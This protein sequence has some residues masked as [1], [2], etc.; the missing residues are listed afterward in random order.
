M[1]V[2]AAN[3]HIQE[4]LPLTGQ[5]MSKYN[6]IVLKLITIL[7]ALIGLAAIIVAWDLLLISNIHD[8]IVIV[9]EMGGVAFCLIGYFSWMYLKRAT[10]QAEIQATSEDAR[11]NGDSDQ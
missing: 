9:L 5:D 1:L 10:K 4:A 8:K 2:G 11:T 3:I 6:I 7:I